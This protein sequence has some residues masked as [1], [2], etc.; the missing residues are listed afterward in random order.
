MVYHDSC[1]TRWCFA[2]R[3]V[4]TCTDFECIGPGSGPSSGSSTPRR[5][6]AYAPAASPLA[7]QVA[8]SWQARAVVK[9]AKATG[10]VVITLWIHWCLGL[11]GALS[12]GV[13]RASPGFLLHGDAKDSRFEALRLESKA[14]VTK[15]FADSL[16]MFSVDAEA[17]VETMLP[18]VPANPNPTGA[19]ATSPAAASEPPLLPKTATSAA[20]PSSEAPVLSK[21]APPEKVDAPLRKKEVSSC[22]SGT[23]SA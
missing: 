6:P 15:V 18:V 11:R 20:A 2:C 8:K 1:R 23:C 9:V 21:A 19:E 4:G 13:S 22:V 10:I 14:L 7:S 16:A 12:I 3:R 5:G 17:I